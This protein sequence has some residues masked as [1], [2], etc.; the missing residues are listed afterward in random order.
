MPVKAG[1]IVIDISAGTGKFVQDMEVAKGKIREFGATGVSETKATRAAF[2][3]LEGDMFSN[4][5][6]AEVFAE[7]LLG[8]GNVAKYAFPVIGLA[9]FGGFVVETGTKVAEFFRGLA[10]APEK[11]KM[12]FRGL[13]DPIRLTNDELAV[14]NDK[15][16]NE[17]AKLEGRPQNNLKLALD[18]AK[19]SADELSDSI[20]KGF[21]ALDKLL[22]EQSVSKW[23]QLFGKAGTSDLEGEH[24]LFRERVSGITDEGAA[25][26]RGASSKLEADAA[27]TE[28]NTRLMSEYGIE[29]GK[30]NDLLKEAERRQALHN[31][32]AFAERDQAARIEALRGSERLLQAER[33]NISLRGDNIKLGGRKEELSAGAEGRK[34]AEETLVRLNRELVEAKAAQATAMGRIE[35]E[36]Q[37]ELE[38][39]QAANQLN[40]T[41]MNLVHGIYDTKRLT[42]Y[43]HEAEQFAEMQIQ[44]A[45]KLRAVT[46]HTAEMYAPGIAVAVKNLEEGARAATKWAEQVNRISAQSGE[47]TLRHN[48]S[49]AGINGNPNDPLGTLATQQA[50]QRADIQD[51]YEQKLAMSNKDLDRFTA[52]QEKQL[53]LQKLQY[54]WEEKTAELRHKN[55]DDF[56]N[57]QRASAKTAGD[58]LYEEGNSAVDRVSEQFGKLLTG[59]KTNFKDMFRGIFEDITKEATKSAIQKG[60]GKL[61]DL[62]GKK[63]APLGKPDGTAENPFHVI[64]DDDKG[65]LKNPL[66]DFAP[67]LSPS[68]GD[69]SGLGELFGA[70]GALGGL[71]GAASGAAAGATEVVTSTITYM[72]GGGDVYPGNIYNVAEA[73]EGELITPKNASTIT[74]ISKLMNGAG[75]GGD[76]YTYNIDARAADLGAGN[77]VARAIEYA[78]NLAVS[79][80]LKASVERAK[81]TPQR[82]G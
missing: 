50:I 73:G 62:F 46:Q 42:E 8:V 43:R 53:A 67:S 27:R 82:R 57:E 7:K 32:S 13:T 47:A 80:G 48:V 9:A 56:I 10:E 70:F 21:S 61:G 23:A 35:I 34:Q 64:V 45:E 63:A 4:T 71:F 51:R 59:Q 29:I 20:E 44:W 66:E 15:L 11:I 78:H 28:M 60:I 24:G 41:T 31:N 69:G 25:K 81:R 33:D 79:R 37:A 18:E 49:M 26:I 16:G 2:K 74:P 38:R 58:I 19:K 17:I 36:E 1:Q 72:A 12:A 76:Q 77:R 40:E 39:L 68:A 75:G 54:E 5:K 55:L 65:S 14:S 6:A 30:V 22:K 3:A 52:L